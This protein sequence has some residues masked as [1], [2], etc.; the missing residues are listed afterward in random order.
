[1]EE[2]GKERLQNRKYILNNYFKCKLIK[3][4][5]PVKRLDE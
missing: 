5:P 4:K 3:I 1:M 2:E